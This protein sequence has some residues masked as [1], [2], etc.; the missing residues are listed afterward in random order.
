MGAQRRD[1]RR[2]GAGGVA[3][4]QDRAIGQHRDAHVSP[5]GYGVMNLGLFNKRYLAAGA[6]CS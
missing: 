6:Y 5:F 2:V 1:T 4:V 3:F